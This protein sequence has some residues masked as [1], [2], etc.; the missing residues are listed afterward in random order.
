MNP[1]SHAVYCVAILIMYQIILLSK[2]IHPPLKLSMMV[3][4]SKKHS[5]CR[6]ILVRFILSKSAEAAVSV[7]LVLIKSRFQ[8]LEFFF[9]HL[10]L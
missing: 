6:L 7:D 9:G 2:T 4:S 10:D 3:R 8:S 1:S 5:V